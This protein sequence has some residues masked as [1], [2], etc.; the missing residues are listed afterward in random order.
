MRANKKS[1]HNSILLVT[2]PETGNPT[3][4][5]RSRTR[6]SSWGKWE[7][8]DLTEDGNGVV[9]LTITFSS[10]TGTLTFKVPWKDKEL[11][12]LPNRHF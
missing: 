1:E 7:L 2:Q 6:Y 3:L 12:E 5:G 4:F 11:N 10:G 9:F 8:R